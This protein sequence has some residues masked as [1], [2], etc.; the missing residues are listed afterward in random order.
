MNLQVN[1]IKKYSLITSCAAVI[2][3]VMTLIAA[4]TTKKPD[5]AE[6]TTTAETRGVE[7]KV[8]NVPDNRIY[9]TII[10]PATEMQTEQ[11][12][13]ATENTT[14]AAPVS[15]ALPLGTDMGKDYSRGIPVY[16]DIMADWRTHDG[17]DFNGE[18][19]DGVKA[20]ADG[21]IRD[22]YNDEIMGPTIV[23][24]HGGD[25]I[26]TYSGVEATENLKK[27]MYVEKCDKI[28][29][30]SSVP[31]ESD[32]EFPHLH[33]EIAVDGEISDPLEVMGMYE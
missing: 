13:A 27:G 33:L 32:S 18:Y 24:D 31:S 22:I 20:I 7:V 14:T 28:G 8:T 23:I 3:A 10:V 4:N 16:N 26:A 12:T 11:T 21:Y 2:I 17:V 30:L 29:I 15:Y 1:K 9:E 5:T 6:T 25:I 19:G